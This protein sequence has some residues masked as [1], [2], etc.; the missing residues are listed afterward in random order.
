M[1]N[2]LKH[3]LII[4]SLLMI[5][6]ILSFIVY[7]KDKTLQQIGRIE[8]EK[9]GFTYF[10][11]NMKFMKSNLSFTIYCLTQRNLHVQLIKKDGEWE[12]IS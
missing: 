2:R 3:L 5:I 9:L 12:R 8:C 10:K 6:F 7:Q 11:T 1:K 4:M